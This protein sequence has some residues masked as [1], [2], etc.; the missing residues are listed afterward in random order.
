MALT[1]QLSTTSWQLHSAQSAA[2]TWLLPFSILKTFGHIDSQVPQPMQIS[3]LT[4][5]FGM[6]L[7]N[8]Y[9]G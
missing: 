1:G 7:F 8:Y 5:A 4:F 3:S 9:L 2:T 6:F